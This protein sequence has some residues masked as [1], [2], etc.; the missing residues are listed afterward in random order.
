M[1][2]ESQGQEPFSPVADDDE[3][4][5]IVG[6]ATVARIGGNP[7][8]AERK[9]RRPLTRDELPP[10]RQSLMPY[11]FADQTSSGLSPSLTPQPG[12][13]E[14]LT[15][16][17][18]RG[19]KYQTSSLAPPIA[20][21]YLPPPLS[22]RRLPFSTAPERPPSL[23]YSSQGMSQPQSREPNRSQHLRQDTMESTSWLDTIDESDG[24]SS[25]CSS[26][27]SR[28]LSIGV[29]RK[30]IRAP[31]GATEAEFDAALDAAVEAAYD[32]GFELADDYEEDLATQTY[33]RSIEDDFVSNARRNV[34][35]AKQRVREAEREAALLAAKDHERKRVQAEMDGM[36]KGGSVDLD[37]SDDEAEEEERILEEMT[38]DYI[39][40]EVEFDMQSKSALPRQS[41]SSGFS[42]RTWGSSIGS[43][44]A[45]A[46]TSLSTVAEGNVLPS[47]ALQLQAK[48]PLPPSLPPPA[49]ALPPPPIVAVG[50]AVSA[51]NVPATPSPTPPPKIKP[52]RLPSIGV[53]DRRLS[54]QNVKQL[55]IEVNSKLPADGGPK[56]QPVPEPSPLVPAEAVAEAPKSASLVRDS[57][58]LL[59]S[60]IFNLPE[61]I[62]AQVVQ[63]KAASPAP[64]PTVNET[65]GSPDTPALT[66]SASVDSED[67]VPVAPSSPMRLVN[68]TSTSS[69][70]LRKKLSSSSLKNRSLSVSTPTASD[71]SPSTPMSTV[72]TA[73]LQTRKDPLPAVPAMPTPIVANF[74]SA[75]P[76]TAGI[77]FIENGIYSPNGFTQPD[78]LAGTTPLPLEPCPESYFL[79]PFWLLRCIYNITAHPRGGYLSGRLF[80]PRDIWRVKNVKIKGI[81]DKVA[82]L[83]LLTAALL[84]LGKADTL[85]AD[86]LLE[87][88]QSFES[89]LDQVK[90]TLTKKI[91]NEV[92]VQGSAA[93]FKGSAGADEPSSTSEALGSKSANVSSKL[94]LHSWRKL[95]PK[96]SSGVGLLP[97]MTTTTNKNGIRETLTM[98]S[99][100]MTSIM[101]PRFPKRDPSQ[102]ECVGPY[103]N[104]MSALAR[105]CDAAQVLGSCSPLNPQI[106]FQITD[107]VCTDEIVRQ[108]EDPGLKHTSQ[109]HVG[110]EFSTQHAAEF[111]GFYVCRFVLND[112]GMM[113]DKFIKRGTE[114]V[115]T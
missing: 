35:L 28:T 50:P 46:G 83:D 59:P 37:Y 24:S 11:T 29:R 72:F 65:G 30:R 66:K 93:L 60:T 42:G 98:K 13:Q 68:K 92:G 25:S 104:Y 14:T 33:A 67:S 99:L 39:M 94:Y 2:N 54:G 74:V 114:W 85:D 19:P 8:Q 32:D 12:L 40:D 44:P 52:P 105:L 57:Q 47:L 63:Q 101:N 4:M 5:A 26:V 110:L 111:F 18:N 108:V 103:A 22:P 9:E 91:G 45:T 56:T 86:A 23:A 3:D 88:M 34:E 100:P 95:R 113:L 61:P 10:R 43:N 58:Q 84:K 109:T 21:E 49:A 78:P 62:T 71:D 1:S 81:E 41:D 17:V 82:A 36:A 51:S 69:G 106:V 70:N 87:E 77:N 90:T 48:P 107:E 112:I 102:V 80:V 27:H 53:R 64:P 7:Q 115:S 31:S 97:A 15:N 96:N 6:T 20:M 79:R 16:S 76:P 75:G 89:V 55:K 73:A 38:R